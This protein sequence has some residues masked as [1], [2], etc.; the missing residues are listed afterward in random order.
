MKKIK[1]VVLKDA[2]KLSNNQ[3]KEIRGGV[4]GEP[5]KSPTCSIGCPSGSVRPEETRDCLLPG[6]YCDYVSGADGRIGVGCYSNET[7]ELYEG[8][9]YM[10]MPNYCEIAPPVE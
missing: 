8:G 1:A 2:T 7:H 9:H 4:T 6:Y 10:F 3:M 5:P